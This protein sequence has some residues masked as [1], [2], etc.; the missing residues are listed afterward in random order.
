MSHEDCNIVLSCTSV[1][2]VY[3]KYIAMKLRA[4]KREALS[5]RQKLQGLV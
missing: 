5:G 2:G 4:S 3:G 1:A